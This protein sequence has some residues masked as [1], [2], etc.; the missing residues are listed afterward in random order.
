M[1]TKTQ[2]APK[3]TFAENAAFQLSVAFEKESPLIRGWNAGSDPDVLAA[4][5]AYNERERARVKAAA[6]AALKL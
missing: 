6:L 4:V 1:S 5:T 3:M 2:T